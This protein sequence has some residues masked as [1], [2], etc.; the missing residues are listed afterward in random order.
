M[1]YI[2][3]FRK[4]DNP[5]KWPTLLQVATPAI[6]LV[7]RPF[8]WL[9]RITDLIFD[10]DARG[11]ASNLRR[12]TKEVESDCD[13]LFRKYGG[14]IVPELSGGSPS[15]D[16]AS[17][18]VE[19][20]SLQ[21]RASRDRGYTS[22]EITS[23]ES[24]EP[25]QSLELVCQRFAPMEGFSPSPLSQLADHLPEIEQLFAGDSREPTTHL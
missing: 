12:L 17:V 3:T 20:R 5:G 11:A 7:S 23:P 18:V 24:R 19:V 6:W 4:K 8:V 14:R 21:L 2:T 25:W 22:W 10:L 1:A 13:H 9:Y 15:M 16:F